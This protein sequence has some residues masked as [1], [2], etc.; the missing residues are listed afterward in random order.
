MGSLLMAEFY[1]AVQKD[2]V[3]FGYASWMALLPLAGLFS[4]VLFHSL[5]SWATAFFLYSVGETV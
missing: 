3:A 4:C 2:L 1:M 5:P